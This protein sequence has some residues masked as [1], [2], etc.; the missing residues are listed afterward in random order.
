MGGQETVKKLLALDQEVI[1]I[2][3]S[4][5]ADDPVMT[6]FAAHGFQG[7]IK[8]PYRVEDVAGVLAAVMGS[9]KQAGALRP[10]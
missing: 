8:K 5:Y 10:A 2:V 3:S 7:V 1:S 9:K 6:Q 4:G